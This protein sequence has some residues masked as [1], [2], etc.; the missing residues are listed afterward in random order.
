MVFPLPI[1]WKLKISPLRKYSIMAIF[2]VGTI[3]II[4]SIIRVAQ[5]HDRSGSR[6]PS[7]SWLAL[8]AMIE[9]AIGRASADGHL[10]LILSL[11][12]ASCGC[13]L[14]AYFRPTL[15]VPKTEQSGL[16]KFPLPTEELTTQRVPK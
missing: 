9:T 12:A 10:P 4:T 15:S 14:P 11:T 7:P 13:R 3:C 2:A 5:I 6:Q 1:L 8:W 16:L